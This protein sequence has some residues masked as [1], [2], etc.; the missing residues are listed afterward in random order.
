MK[1]VPLVVFI[2]KKSGGQVGEKIIRSM[3]RWLNPLQIF[4]L[5]NG[6]PGPGLKSLE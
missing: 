5:A 3:S 6:G 4:D 2:N 1:T